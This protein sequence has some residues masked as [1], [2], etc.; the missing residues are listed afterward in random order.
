M[1]QD[2]ER[3]LD[4]CMQSVKNADHIIYIDGG[5][6]DNSIKIARSYGAEIIEHPYDQEDKAMNGKQRNVYLKYLKEHYPD[7]W[8]LALD[9]DEVV[10]DLSKFKSFIQTAMPGIYSPRMRHLIQDLAHEDSINKIHPVLNRLFKIGYATKYPEVEHPVLQGTGIVQEIFRDTTIWH[11][12]YVPNLWE[13]KKRYDSHMKKSNMHTPEYLKQWYHQHLFGQYPK[14]QFN[15]VELPDVILKKFGVDKDELYFQGRGLEH[16]H[17]IDSVNWRDYFK[18]KTAIEFG[19]GRGPRVFAMNQVGIKAMGVE[20]SKYAVKTKMHE[21]VKR[22]N[23]L[24]YNEPVGNFD[25]TIAYDL[26]EHIDYKDL[27]KAIST[28]YTFS[29]KY[30]LVSVPVLGDPNLE[31]D[32]TH[33]IKETKEWWIKQFVDKGAKHIKT[34]DHFLYRNQVIIF[35]KR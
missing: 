4:M 11:L 22:G 31:L 25:L 16:K 33:I 7:E 30:I 29:D 14:S 3:F 20:L 21:E 10:E 2:G 19:C 26:L 28:L 6:K 24:D 5:S 18:C 8:N 35:E 27:D 15:P 9:A 32:P 1:G 34:P 13:I 17:W 12:A 23:V